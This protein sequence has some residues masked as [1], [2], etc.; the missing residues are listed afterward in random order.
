MYMYMYTYTCTCTILFFSFLIDRADALGKLGISY[1]VG[2][3][4]GPTLGGWL[5]KNYS[6]Q[7]AAG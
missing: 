3:I 7:F 6:E 1:G 2:M 4:V 5:A